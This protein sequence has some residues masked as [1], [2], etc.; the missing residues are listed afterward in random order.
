MNLYS[1]ARKF[2]TEECA[3][4]RERDRLSSNPNLSKLAI[5]GKYNSLIYGC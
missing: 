4:S 5:S 1:L 3:M 2:P